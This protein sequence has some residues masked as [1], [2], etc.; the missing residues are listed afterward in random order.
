MK[1]QLS[2]V[3]IATKDDELSSM[4]GFTRVIIETEAE[5]P[6]RTFETSIPVKLPSSQWK[7]LIRHQVTYTVSDKRYHAARGHEW[8][9][10]NCISFETVRFEV[11]SGCLGGFA[12][13]GT[14]S[15]FEWRSEFNCV[16]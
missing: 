1:E 14:R 3:L 15:S 13:T 11:T 10:F 6:C 5:G 4:N 8:G 9:P 12:V 16:D 2:G 7:E